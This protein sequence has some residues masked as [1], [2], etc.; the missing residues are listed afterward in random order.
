MGNVPWVRIYAWLRSGSNRPG[1]LAHLVLDVS[2]YQKWITMPEIREIG[3]RR[4][5]GISVEFGGELM[6]MAP[7]TP[8]RFSVQLRPALGPQRRSSDYRIRH[9][10]S[11]RSAR[12]SFLAQP[13]H[14]YTVFI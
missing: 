12:R 3:R 14:R 6:V 7:T 8:S 13:R 11:R 1:T 5:M 2:Y 10:P 9:T 4:E